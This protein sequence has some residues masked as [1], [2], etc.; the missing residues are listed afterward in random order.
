MISY[1]M[2]QRGV[3]EGQGGCEN[4]DDEER[5]KKDEDGKVYS[6]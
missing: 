6:I 5:N 3:D 2:Y 4:E 1:T